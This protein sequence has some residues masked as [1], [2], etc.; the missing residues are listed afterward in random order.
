MADQLDVDPKLLQEAADGINKIVGE[1]SDVGIES[2]AVVGRGFSDTRLSPMEAGNES[3]REAFGTF[4]DRWSWGVR[5]LVQDGNDIADTLNLAAGLYHEED[6]E[7]SNTFKEAYADLTSNPHLTAQQVDAQS[8][9]QTLSDNM[10]NNALHPDYSQKS[11][12]QM[13][14]H[15]SNDARAVIAAAPGVVTNPITPWKS[16]DPAAAAKAR[17]ILGQPGQK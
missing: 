5:A 6:E 9:G 8:W 10:V 12:E 1:L 16:A 4:C 14:A 11:F 15:N 13:A 7:F 2:T 17:A 3:V